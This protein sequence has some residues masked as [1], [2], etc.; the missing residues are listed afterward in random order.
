TY[1]Y[2]D[3]GRPTTETWVGTNQVIHYGYDADSNLTS[4]ADA[5][6]SLAYTYD[7]RNRIKTASNA[8]TP[9]T[10]T[11]VLTYGYDAAGN[12]LSLADTV[13]GQAGGLNSD[14]FHAPNHMTQGTQTRAG[15][16][17]KRV[18][19]SYKP[20]GQVEA[21]LPYSDLA[22]TQLVARATYG[23]DPLNRPSALTYQNA[24]GATVAS[25]GLTFNDAGRVT[26]ATDGDGTSGYTYDHNGQLT[27][28]SHTDPAN[29]AESY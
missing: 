22:G 17:D 16:H 2:D 12:V 9:D 20:G 27:G 21:L 6:S 7:N 23:Y 5:F 15:L 4:V 1:A 28:A 19:P 8:G 26:Q 3:L 18:D 13:G 29:P 25:Y 10:P 14:R 11:V 24:A